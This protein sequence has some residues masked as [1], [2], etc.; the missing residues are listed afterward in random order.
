MTADLLAILRCPFCGTALEVIDNAALRRVDGAIETGV[1]GC[2]CCAF[3]VVAGIPVLIADDRVREAMHALEAGHE[4]AALARLLGL[5]DA[6]RTAFEAAMA[7]A[8]PTYRDVLAILSED[9]EGTYFVYRFSDP[10]YVAA[11]GLV[12]ALT[13]HARLGRRMID[14]CGGS[15]H[16]TRDL[17]ASHPRDGVVLADV[18]F[19][20]LWLAGRFVAPGCEP[21]CCDGN[22][23]LP[24]ARDTFSLAVLSDAFPYIWHKRML[25]DEL[26]RLAGAEGVVAMPHLH[27]SLGFNHSAGMTLTPEAYRDLFSALRPRLYRDR[28]LLDGV[29]ENGAVDLSQDTPADQLDDEPAVTLVASRV[30]DVFTRHVL[31]DVTDIT[32]ELRVN[33]LYAIEWDGRRSTLTLGFPTPEYEE[34][35]GESRRFLPDRVAVA[36]DL[37]GALTPALVGGDYVELR[38]RR[39]LIDAPY[40]YY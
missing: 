4:D 11:Q 27:S 34:E 12:R 22:A 8:S 7:G 6:R 20:K 9:A 35:F 10:T 21:V 18:Y 40:G 5:D 14:V 26:V 38:R 32:G 28:Q 19:A 17:L 24:F 23:P 33:P 15:G 1:I 3:P 25:A 2:Q 37:R 39:V 36:A 16:L 13:Q 29:L 30:D 31:P